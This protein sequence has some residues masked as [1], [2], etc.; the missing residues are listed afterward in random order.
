[1]EVNKSGETM[2]NRLDVSKI[3]SLRWS[4]SINLADGL[5]STYKWAVSNNV[6]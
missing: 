4:A 5:K 2:L 6:F 3:V 1:M